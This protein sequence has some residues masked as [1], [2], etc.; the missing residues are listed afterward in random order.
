MSAR[1]QACSISATATD[2]NGNTSEFA[3]DVTVTALYGGRG[4]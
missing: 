3:Q 2:P 4:A 1:L